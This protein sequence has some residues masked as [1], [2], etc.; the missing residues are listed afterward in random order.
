MTKWNEIY[1][2]ADFEMTLGRHGMDITENPDLP[3]WVNLALLI[4]SNFADAMGGTYAPESRVPN[5]FEMPESEEGVEYANIR[6]YA[7][8]DDGSDLLING[9]TG[10]WFF[11]RY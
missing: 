9:I 8:L 11:H 3:L 5:N 10:E 2:E 4:Q 1:S 7:N 6:L